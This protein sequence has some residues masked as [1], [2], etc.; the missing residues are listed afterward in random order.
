MGERAA[1]QRSAVTAPRIHAPGRLRVGYL[2]GSGHTGSTL[3]ALFMDTHPQIVSV[4]ETAIKAGRR[5]AARPKRLCSCGVP[6]SECRFWKSVF[7]A[8]SQ[9]GHEL[10]ASNWSNDYRYQSR[11]LHLALS[12]YSSIRPV[13]ALQDIAG[14]FLPYHRAR[15]RETNEVN[16]EFIR[17]AMQIAGADV[18]FDT[19]KS[20]MRLQHLLRVPELDIRVVLLVRDVRGFCSSAKRRGQAVEEAASAW[21]KRHRLLAEMA[22]Q[23]PPERVTSLRYEDLCEDPAFRLKEL[24]RFLQVEVIEPP[25]VV[26]PRDHH[27]LGNR[28]RREGAIRIRPADDWSKTLTVSETGEVLRIAGRTN[29]QFGYA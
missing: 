26:V 17:A 23:L 12:R 13:R 8:V 14:R 29:E 1:G 11:L 24:Q 2:T 16:V 21:N 25:E 15:V 28:I 7:E 4:G 19:S 20:P 3:L 27:V 10:N 22:A 18:F 5:S 6:I 9:R